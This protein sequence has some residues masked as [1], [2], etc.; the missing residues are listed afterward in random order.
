ML[1]PCVKTSGVRPLYTAGKSIHRPTVKVYLMVYLTE[2]KRSTGYILHELQLRFRTINYTVKI[3]LLTSRFT[4]NNSR[5]VYLWKDA[6]V[7]FTS[8]NE[9]TEY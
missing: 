8:V 7:E 9:N 3:A 2:S 1:E 6:S 4:W 5:Y